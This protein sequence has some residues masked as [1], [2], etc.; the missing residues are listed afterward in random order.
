MSKK[1]SILVA[2]DHHL[3]R[4]G[5]IIMLNEQ[6]SF[7]FDFHEAANGEEVLQKIKVVPIDLILLDITMPIM[8]GLAT[9]KKLRALSSAPPTVMLTMHND[10]Y[11]VRQAYKYGTSGFVLKTCTAAELID[12]IDTVS[13]GKKYFSTLAS[14]LLF[15]EIKS[16]T[17]A[18][19]IYLNNELLT[20]RE[21]GII[22]MYVKGYTNAKVATEL[23][24]SIRTVE[25]HRFKIMK[26][27]N[28]DNFS[29]L[30]LY[31]IENEF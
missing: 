27:L 25:G 9:L 14:N 16:N 24:I 4:E 30:I 1:L 19:R 6:K 8:D 26:K 2:D 29:Q 18:Q 11:I 31:G 5:I 13:N 23:N 7:S 21:V 12:A 3:V 10:D 28:L 22:S 15:N 20:R 17:K